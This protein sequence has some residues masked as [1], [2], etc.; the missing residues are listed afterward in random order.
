[1]IKEAI[2]GLDLIRMAGS[3]CNVGFTSLNRDR[4]VFRVFRVEVPC[5]VTSKELMV[6]DLV[7]SSLQLLYSQICTEEKKNTE[8]GFRGTVTSIEIVCFPGMHLAEML[9]NYAFCMSWELGC[10]TGQSYWN[11]NQF[12]ILL[13]Q[14][15]LLRTPGKS[16]QMCCQV[17]FSPY[18]KT[19]YYFNIEGCTCMCVYDYLAICF[20]L[21]GLP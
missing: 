13:Y 2:F 21:L 11:Q 3:S 14:C 6:R 20:S 12:S 17:A 9:A 1:M 7:S 16:L 8:S 4:K 15:T 5:D 10:S 18:F 19:W